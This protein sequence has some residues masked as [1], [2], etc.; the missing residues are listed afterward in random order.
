MRK[1]ALSGSLLVLA[2]AAALQ[3]AEVPKEQILYSRKSGQQYRIHVMDGDGKND[4]EVRGQHA[5]MNILPV[6]SP[7]GERIAYMSG[8]SFIGPEHTVAVYDADGTSP[9]RVKAPGARAGMAV[10]SP[11]GKHLALIAGTDENPAVFVGDGEGNDLRQVSPPGTGAMFPFWTGDSSRI[12]FTR[13]LPPAVASELVSVKPDGSDLSVLVKSEMVVMAGSGATTPDG[14]QFL[15]MQLN[16]LTQ[17]AMLRLHD[18]AD[19]ADRKLVDVAY[20]DSKI[21]FEAFLYPSWAKDGKSFLLS[22]PSAKGIGIYRYNANGTG[23]TRITPE[24]IDCFGPSLRSA[25]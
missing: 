1:L 19:N 23:K 2:V 9:R 6:W 25:P 5:N 7:D 3:A 16:P 20:P 14:K 8:A 18:F 17:K 4:R 22:Q 15:Y 24:G 10:W 21:S 13:F 12:C 11:D